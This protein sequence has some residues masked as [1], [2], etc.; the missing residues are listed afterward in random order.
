MLPSS[1][2]AGPRGTLVMLGGGD[3]DPMLAMLA[4]LIPGQSAIIEVLTTATRRQPARTA[5]A[6]AHAWHQLDCP[7]VRHLRV[8]ELH[9]ADDPAT[10]ARLR[11][12]TLIFMSGGDQ[13][14]LT[15]FLLGTEFLAILKD[16]YQNETGFVLAGTSAGASAMAE[17]M[18]VYGHGWRSLK[19][20]NIDVKPGLG[21]LPGVVLDQ[22]FAERGR[23]PRLM[24]AVLTQPDLLGVG[25]SEETGIIISPDRLA[26]VFGDEVVVVVDA[27]QV[28]HSNLTDLPDGQMISGHGLCLHLLVAGQQL[29]L[30]S[31]EV[32]K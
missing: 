14:R 27:T 11:K 28:T 17:F 19:R 3:D 15:D 20:G 29:N 8:D 1:S 7:H 13:E 23:Y 12:A 5:A 2:V 18:L 30:A 26:Q 4:G 32:I 9:P 24:H 25:L 21:L 31:R 6:Y 10:L 16:K 22:H